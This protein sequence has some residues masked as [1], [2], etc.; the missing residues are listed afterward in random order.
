MEELDASVKRTNEQFFSK[1]AKGKKKVEQ[2]WLIEPQKLR[3][4]LQEKQKEKERG[5]PTSPLSDY[6]RTLS[7]E[8]KKM[9]KTK[10]GVP[11]LGEQEV[12][13]VPPLVIR[14]E[15]GSNI[16]QLE[17]LEIPTDKEVNLEELANFYAMQG[18][19]IADLLYPAADVVDTWRKYEH[20]KSLWNPEKLSELG[21]Q[22]YKLNKWYLEACKRNEVALCIRI[23]DKHWY[24]GNDVMYMEFSEL[25]QL[26]HLDSLDKTFMSCYCLYEMG[27]MRRRSC[28][29][30]G[31]IDPHIVYKDPK[32]PQAKW[33]AE[34]TDN[35]RKALQKQHK[36]D[37][38][39]FPYNYGCAL[40][41]HH[42]LY[43]ISMFTISKV[44]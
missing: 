30:I 19:D 39:L 11:Q 16:K 12:Q 22:M 32:M 23:R 10:K 38:I 6:D 33:Q 27:L 36:K 26:C 25:H 35:I 8:V 9:A 29:N 2:P 24:R 34:M 31:F 42:I 5:K 3:T 18:Y 28:T 41:F 37:F 13:S 15:Y 4:M 21:T 7:K 40:I 44:T 1:A 17:G 43:N 14:D 20:G